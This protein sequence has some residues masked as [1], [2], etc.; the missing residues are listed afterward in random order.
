[1]ATVQNIIPVICVLTAWLMCDA[2][3][4]A[5]AGLVATAT[6]LPLT[7]RGFAGC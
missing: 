3:E 6:W 7:L 4:E 5:A 2:A 1:M